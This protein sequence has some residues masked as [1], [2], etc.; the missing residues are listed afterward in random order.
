MAVDFRS[1]SITI[2]NGTGRR[3][4][5]GAA[6][7]GSQVIRAGVALNGFRLDYANGD[8]HVNVVEADVDILAITANTVRFRVECL[9]ADK[10]FDDP[11]SGYVTA[12][13]T[14]EVS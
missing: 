8:K 13:V 7:F 11:Y 5:E 14:A 4:I 2:P 6:V 10:N 12:L 1:V 9:L 3:S